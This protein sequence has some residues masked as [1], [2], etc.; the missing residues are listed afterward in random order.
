MWQ[1]IKMSVQ[2]CFWNT[3]LLLFGRW[4]KKT[5]DNISVSWHLHLRLLLVPSLFLPFHFLLLRRFLLRSPSTLETTR[6]DDIFAFVT[7]EVVTVRLWAMVLVEKEFK[8]VLLNRLARQTDSGNKEPR[9]ADKQSRK[10]IGK[11]NIDS[12]CWESKAWLEYET[13]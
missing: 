8:K 10:R 6:T 7:V 4:L 12:S 1:H 5:T 2:I 11:R 3:L 9:K 13:C